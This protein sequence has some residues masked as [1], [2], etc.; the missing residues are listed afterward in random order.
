MDVIQ[1]ESDEVAKG[2]NTLHV[3]LNPNQKCSSRNPEIL[4]TISEV[5]T[6]WYILD[7][8]KKIEILGKKEMKFHNLADLIYSLF[9]QTWFAFNLVSLMLT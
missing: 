5:Y 9:A 8:S 3:R 2:Q 1:K 4:N 6:I 7:E